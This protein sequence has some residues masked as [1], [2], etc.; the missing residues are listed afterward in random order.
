M[1]REVLRSLITLKALTFAPTGGIVAAP[2]TSLP[3]KIGGVRNWDYRF[4]WLRDATFTL[5]ALMINGYTEEATA[6]RNW[7]LR[8]VAGD[9]SQLHIMYGVHGERRL[10]ELELP[11]L[12]GYEKSR[13]VRIGNA[14]VSQLQLD[15]YGEVMDALHLARRAGIP[16]DD[17]AWSLQKALLAFLETAWSQP[18][19]G[20]WEVRGPPP[21]HLFQGDGLGG[22]RSR[23]KGCRAL[24]GRG[25]SGSVAAAP[26]SSA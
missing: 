19:E 25:S 24:W 18:D 3:E 5:C 6:W 22:V 11:W 14:A 12:P 26:R 23:D 1:A 16:A 15:V 21:F 9:P 2:T 10:T 13:P 17:Y 4:C 8:A 7:L 20:I